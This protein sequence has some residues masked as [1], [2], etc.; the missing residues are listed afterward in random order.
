MTMAYR[1]NGCGYTSDQPLKL[2]GEREAGEGGGHPLPTGRFDL[3]ANCALIA[4]AALTEV[5]DP[6]DAFSRARRINDSVARRRQS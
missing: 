4:F 6:D 1:C 5:R 2:T 3:C